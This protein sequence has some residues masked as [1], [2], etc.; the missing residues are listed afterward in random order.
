MKIRN[1]PLIYSITVFLLML[2][3]AGWYLQSLYTP[4]QTTEW[5]ITF[6]Q[7]HA[8]YLGFDWKLMYL[9]M[10]ND[11]KPKKLRLMTYWENIEPEPEKYDFSDAALMLAEAEK[12]GIDV[13]LVVG[14]KQPR[15]PECHHPAWYANLS[16]QQKQEAQLRFV[17][18]TVNYYRQFTAIKTWQVENEALFSF[19]DDCP[20]TPLNLIQKEMQIIREVDPR[21]ILMTD[22]G[23]LGRWVPTAKL[24]PDVFGST[25]YR[26]V[27]NPRV[28][29]FKYPLPPTFFKVKAGLTEKLTD[30]KAENIIGVELQAE[31]WFSDD[32]YR[33]DLQTQYALMNDKILKE[34]VDYAQEVGFKE[35]YL[36]GVEWW[37]WLAHTHGDWGMWNE[38]KNVLVEN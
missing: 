15:W 7:N 10:L 30:I 6:S 19:G 3:V 9:D 26:V 38:A 24:K 34:Y 18:N 37:Y 16:E 17:K 29:Y 1:K 2:L 32:I 28:G 14:H 36:W 5:G 12:R 13:I 11:L 25:M 8:R 22:S 21:P 4:A 31:P 35:N 27:H 20:Q 33:T 23:E